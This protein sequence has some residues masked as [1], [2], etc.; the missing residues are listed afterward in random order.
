MTF[1]T[2]MSTFRVVRI[3]KIVL[4]GLH[5]HGMKAFEFNLKPT[6]SCEVQVNVSE[7]GSP[8]LLIKTKYFSLKRNLKNRKI[9]FSYVSEHCACIVPKKMVLRKNKNIHIFFYHDNTEET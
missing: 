2:L 3:Q 9:I 5:P 1:L 6:G 7:S 4:G 8:N